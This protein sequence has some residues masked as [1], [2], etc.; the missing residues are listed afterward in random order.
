MHSTKE[1]DELAERVCRYMEKEGMAPKGSRIVAG[2]S[3]GPDSVCLLLLLTQL[4]ASRSWEVAAVHV[5]HLIRQG[6]GEDAQY[7]KELCG[8]LGIPFYLKEEPVEELAKEWNLSVEEAGRRVR[9][10]AF[11]EAAADFG[12][13]RIAVA[14]N[15]ND[16]A[17]TLLFH[18]FRGTGLSGMAS[19]RPVRGKIIRPLLETG[20][21][22]IEAW[23]RER[24]I[25]W[26]IDESND[27]DTYT[28]NKIRRH[29]LPYACSEISGNADIHLAREAE[30]LQ[31]TADYVQRMA[32]QALERC[33]AGKE[34]EEGLLVDAFLKEE[35]FLQTHMLKL[36]LEEYTGGGRDIT[37]A[38]IHKLHSLFFAQS[39]NRIA[40][41][42]G[43]E[44]ERSFHRV[45]LT[46]PGNRPEGDGVPETDL[47]G[48]LL[49]QGS[50]SCTLPDGRILE[51]MVI[52]R[53][54]CEGIEQKTYTK[55]LDY[56]RIK[57]LVLRTRR[58]GDY[59]AVND[60]LQKK[61]LKEY[62]IQE[63]IPVKERPS[64]PLLADGSHI[65]WVIGR[66]ISSAAKMT[67]KTERILRIHIRGGRE[68]D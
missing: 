40:L 34:P 21:E 8:S 1:R 12:A 16:R 53:E 59:L 4:A 65:L 47:T 43:I 22:E 67:E 5:N 49:E 68:D 33:M 60:R 52:P 46:R 42:G 3:G 54:K 61:S 36:L 19:I 18:L 9:Y 13:D 26:R 11:E 64:W 30:L 55:W 14:H 66:R 17:E 20:R 56:D 28:R 6:A 39:G 51:C 15:R 27:T 41:P 32:R 25:L 31:Q 37:S 38:H 62:L 35:A 57:S 58:P 23:L 7:V 48:S 29:I 63:K 10:A 45:V 2:V 24:G 50:A 44:A